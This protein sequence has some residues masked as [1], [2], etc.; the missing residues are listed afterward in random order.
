MLQVRIHIYA[1]M[2][3]IV[4]LTGGKLTV[5]KLCNYGNGNGVD[6]GLFQ[7]ILLFMKLILFLVNFSRTI[8]TASVYLLLMPY[9]LVYE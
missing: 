1:H 5:F 8:R 3:T 4:V 9:F 6:F 7:I 2:R